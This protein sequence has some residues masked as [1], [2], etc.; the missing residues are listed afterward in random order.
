MA[1]GSAQPGPGHRRCSRSRSFPKVT[2]WLLRD[3][4]K[5]AAL[6]EHVAAWATEL[7]RLVQEDPLGED[8]M[9]VLRY[10]SRVAGETTYQPFRQRVA[11]VAP[12]FEEAM[13]SAEQHFIE[14]GIERGIEEGIKLTW[15]RILRARFGAIDAAAEARIAQATSNELDLWTERV[16]VAQRIDDVFDA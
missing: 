16:L 1:V 9:V 11:D 10:I 7:E 12:S 13:A 4:R 2:L 8:V 15:T 14:K 5:A 6:V 3:G